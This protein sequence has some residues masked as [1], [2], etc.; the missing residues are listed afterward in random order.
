MNGVSS[1]IQGTVL[2][3]NAEENQFVTA[4]ET[5]AKIDPRDYQVAAEQ[6]KAQLSQSHADIAAQHPNVPITET[7]NETNISTGQAQV[8]TQL[9]AL[10]AAEQNT[11]AAR[12]AVDPSR[13]ASA[14]GGSQ[15]R[16]GSG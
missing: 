15:Q 2:A 9:A 11:A 16:E 14:R 8:D 7:A 3:V 1:R 4:G 12:Q 6:A 10:A 5:L 13:G